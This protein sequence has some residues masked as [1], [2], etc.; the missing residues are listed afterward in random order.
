[1]TIIGATLQLVPVALQVRVANERLA[2]W[3]FYLYLP[4]VVALLYGFCEPA[5]QLAH[6]RRRAARPGVALYL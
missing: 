5:H 3:V 4:G 2:G 1:M 6:R